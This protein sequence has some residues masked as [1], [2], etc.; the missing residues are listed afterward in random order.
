ML[1]RVFW[2]L[3]T[4]AAAAASVLLISSVASLALK[5]PGVQVFNVR[6]ASAF[7][8]D[9]SVDP[10]TTIEPLSPAVID[11]VL[12]DSASG[13]TVASLAPPL[14]VERAAPALVQLPPQAQPAEAQATDQSAPLADTGAL[15]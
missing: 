12:Q 13:S 10:P 14:A 11:A 4:V 2:P 8:A 5:R 1:E 15:N 9:Y 6:I 7:V 3:F